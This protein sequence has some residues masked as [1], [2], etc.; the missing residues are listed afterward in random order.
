MR[1]KNNFLGKIIVTFA[2]ILV[3]L[4]VISLRNINKDRPLE[5]IYIYLKV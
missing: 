3:I 2:I 1:N 5:M 4:I